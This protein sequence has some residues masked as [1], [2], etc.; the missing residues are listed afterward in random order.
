MDA[1]SPDLELR[2]RTEQAELHVAELK[3][4]LEHAGRWNQWRTRA[5]IVARAAD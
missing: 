1:L 4:A 2:L 3:A 5:R